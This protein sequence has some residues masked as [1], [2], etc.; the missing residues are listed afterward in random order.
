MVSWHGPGQGDTQGVY[1]KLFNSSTGENL[2]DDI[3]V[4]GI[5]EDGQNFASVCCFP[6]NTGFVVVWNGRGVGDDWGIYA[7][8]F[9]STGFNQ[10]DDILL[11]GYWYDLQ[12]FP[13]VCCFP[14]SSGFVAAWQSAGI[15]SDGRDIYVKVFNKT[16]FNQTDDI[17]VNTNTTG[18]QES[19]SVC[20]FSNGYFVVAWQSEPTVDDWDVYVKLFDSS[21]NNLTDDIRVN[22]YT[23][24]EQL[25][26]SVCCFPDSSRFVVTWFGEGQG[27]TLTGVFFR[28][29]HI[30]PT[31]DA[32]LL[33]LGVL[34]IAQ[35]G[36]GVS[37]PLLVGGIL[38]VAVVAGVLVFWWFRRGR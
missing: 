12:Q 8:V 20:C 6:D 14:D 18:D 5:T 24:N 17:K 16:C 7:K 19:P 2:T 31:I 11:N 28:M 32:S 3:L 10:T 15:E 38:V 36:A 4:N 29:G 26:P 13:S 21:G 23:T 34:F 1:V 9:N 37:V 22:I 25:D 30:T 33:L 35:S 27:E